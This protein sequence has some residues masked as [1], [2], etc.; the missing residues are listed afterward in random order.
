MIRRLTLRDINNV[1]T[2]GWD[3]EKYMLHCLHDIHAFRKLVATASDE[4]LHNFMD[5]LQCL[6]REAHNLGSAE[7]EIKVKGS[8]RFLARINSFRTP[9]AAALGVDE[10]LVVPPEDAS[11]VE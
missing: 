7:I 10:N 2:L 11:K 8:D 1:I 9:T 5:S 4:A 3:V 6:L